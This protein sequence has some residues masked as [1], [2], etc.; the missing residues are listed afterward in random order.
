MNQEN[1]KVNCLEV[2]VT[3]EDQS[4]SQVSYYVFDNPGEKKFIS[5]IYTTK[6]IISVI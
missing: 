5:N 2:T 6:L 4:G 3:G 1:Q